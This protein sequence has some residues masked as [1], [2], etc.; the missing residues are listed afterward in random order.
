MVAKIW[1]EGVGLAVRKDQRAD[2]VAQ[3]ACNEQGHG[4]RT[5]FSGDRADEENNDPA[6]QEKGGVRHPDGNLC[7]EDGFQGDEENRQTPDDAKQD[8][9]FRAA[10]NGQTEGRIRS[11][12]EDVDGVMVKDAK[13]AQVFFEEQK[14]M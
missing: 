6:H 14:E 4:S 10:E 12:D 5:Q 3:S 7:K 9:A 1:R 2:R 11:G 13:D 8:P